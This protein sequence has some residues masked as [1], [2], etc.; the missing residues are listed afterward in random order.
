M[1]PQ[2]KSIWIPLLKVLDEAGGSLKPATAVERV[3]KYF[4]ELTPEDKQYVTAH[5]RLRWSQHDVPFVRLDM[6]KKGLLLTNPGEWQISED[7][8]AYLQNS[9]QA[10][11]PEYRRQ[12]GGTPNHRS[13]NSDDRDELP[14]P[15]RYWWV[16]QGQSYASERDGGYVWAP[17]QTT[18][19]G[20]RAHWSRV[21]EIQAGD[22]L[23][24][25]SNGAVRA[26]SIAMREAEKRDN[27]HPG[28]HQAWED[29]GWAANVQYYELPQPYLR[30]KLTT[31]LVRMDISEGPFDRRGQ[32]KQGYL[33]SFHSEAFAM[34]TGDPVFP[35]P[36]AW[37]LARPSETS[38]KTLAARESRSPYGMDEFDLLDAHQKII[39]MGYQIARDDFLNVLLAL[40]VRP[41]VIFSGRSGTGKTT[42]TRII[43]SLFRWPHY[44]VAVSPAWADPADL[45]G[46]ISP[47]NQQRMGGAL[48]DVLLSPGD[49]ALLCLDEF[50][51]AKVE[52][53]FSDFISAMDGGA[54]GSLWGALPNLQRFPEQHAET[55]NWPARL[56]VVATMNFDDS[57]QSITP[58]VLDRANVMEFD[59]SSA[60]ALVVEQ[61]LDWSVLRDTTFQWPWR[62]EDI[63]RNTSVAAI[64][65]SIWPAL[66]GSR[67]HFTH[68]VAQEMHRYIVLGLPFA[69]ALGRT[70]DEQREALF[71]RQ[72]AQRILPKFHGTAANRDMAAL[73]HLLSALSGN[74]SAHSQAL[75]RFQV[76]EE[77]RNG[78]RFPK[79]VAKV[80]QLVTSFTED[81]YASFW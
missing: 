13:A 57:V 70:P 40:Q 42:L 8:R 17:L 20:T 72:I 77:F 58:R 35:W 31:H 1:F 7:G 38:A 75:D 24:H 25:Y 9:W 79:T 48:D 73:T 11:A 69:D 60:D 68:R 18:A 46:F 16:N 74:E 34:L 53:Y 67:G 51:L 33:W 44:M 23:I 80:E 27:P 2:R 61:S 14:P 55:L 76:I 47:M 59:L 64:I 54:E 22:V 37:P 45:I 32:I 15:Q 66:R 6:V 4:P 10:W 71:D 5:G 36:P 62:E 3:E 39:D 28:T 50:N 65:R 21:S 12:N 52:H 41:F 43:A 63:R 19:G 29:Q 81:G 56:R 78:G 30:E 49:Q 26:I